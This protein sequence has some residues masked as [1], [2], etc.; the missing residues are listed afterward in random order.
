MRWTYLAGCVLAAGL[1]TASAGAADTE[2]CAKAMV[3]ASSPQ[4]VVDALQAAGYKGVLSKSKSGN[5]MI[6]SAAS[7]YKFWI[8]FYECEKGAACA[9]IQ[10][11]IT[12]NDDDGANSAELANLWNKD[13]RFSQMSFDPSDRSLSFSYDVTTLGGLNQKNFADVIDWWAT[14][15]GQLGRFFKE[16]PAGK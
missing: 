9:S 13:K 14:M 7:G 5:P 15:L 8:Y 6:E 16:H 10:F 12:F 3:C 2:P 11:N 1:A 4:T